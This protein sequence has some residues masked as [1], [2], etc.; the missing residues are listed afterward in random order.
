LAS[1]APA[2]SSPG[3]AHALGGIGAPIRLRDPAGFVALTAAPPPA[4]PAPQTT[5]QAEAAGHFAG[6]FWGDHDAHHAVRAPQSLYPSCPPQ[7]PARTPLQRLG[8]A[9]HRPVL[10]TSRLA[11]PR[12][13]PS[14][15]LCHSLHF[16]TSPPRAVP[17]GLAG[18]AVVARASC[19]PPG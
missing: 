1:S 12:R 13:Q 10:P 4:P 14:A 17:A 15:P 6:L 16:Q 9:A 3:C 19:N 8:A 7:G 18:P 2:A 5:L 11:G